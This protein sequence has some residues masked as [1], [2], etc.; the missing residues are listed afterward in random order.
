MSKSSPKLRYSTFFFMVFVGLVVSGSVSAIWAR[1]ADS[2]DRDRALPS[3]T[4]RYQD[5]NGWPMVQ[6]RASNPEVWECEVVIVG[7]SLGGVAAAYHSMQTG[8]RTCLIELTPMLGGQ[9]SSQA[10][11]AIDESLLM[12]N[13]QVFST[14]WTHFKNTIAEQVALP[15]ALAKTRR[16]SCSHQ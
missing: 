7:G 16:V 3:Q 6:P 12:R 5:E 11:S 2:S 10:V 9:V 13:H 14:S 15:P 1:L 8:T 4:N